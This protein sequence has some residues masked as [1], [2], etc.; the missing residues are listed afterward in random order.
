VDAPVPI[1]LWSSGTCSSS[2]AKIISARAAAAGFG[3]LFL[4]GSPAVIDALH[5]SFLEHLNV[6]DGKKKRAWAY[7]AMPALVKKACDEM[8]EY[9]CKIH[10]G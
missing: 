1:E 10:G 7:A 4:S 6:A 9:N 3:F 5:V 2:W 8:A